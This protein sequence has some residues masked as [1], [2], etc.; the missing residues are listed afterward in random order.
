MEIF[1]LTIQ[2][3]FTKKIFVAA[4]VF[5]MFAPTVHARIQIDESGVQEARKIKKK[6]YFWKKEL[7]DMAIVGKV[8]HI[9]EN[10]NVI[11]PYFRVT[12][13][14]GGKYMNSVGGVTTSKTKVISSLNGVNEA[15]MQEVTNA[16]YEHLLSQLEEAGYNV[17][18]ISALDSSDKFQS[19]DRNDYPN[20]KKSLSQFTPKGLPY[21]GTIAVKAYMAAQDVDAIML[22]ADYTVNFVVLNENQKKISILRDK[23]DVEVGQGIN[24]FGEL[25]AISDKGAVSFVIQ[26]PI[27]SD[28]PFGE[29][30]NATTAMNKV[31]DGVAT[32]ASLLNGRLGDRRSTNTVEVNANNAEYKVA[33][34]DALT[35]ANQAL[36]GFFVDSTNSSEEE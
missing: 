13:V 25:A 6:R 2:G 28:K 8:K 33:A 22:K 19:L 15:T 34:E 31:S 10:D 1:E 14:T 20:I 32:V 9:P 21:P 4:L 24:V 27:G 35:Q 36:V 17:L 3:D 7:A 5:M 26:Q 16:M 23:S 11:V 12:F 30:E 18:D 29:V